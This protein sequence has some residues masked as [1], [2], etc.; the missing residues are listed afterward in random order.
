MRLRGFSLILLCW[1][2]DKL[3]TCNW[4]DI[5]SS[6]ESFM[7]MCL[8]EDNLNEGSRSLPLPL[9]IKNRRERPLLSF[10]S[11]RRYD[12][13]D[14]IMRGIDSYHVVERHLH[15]SF[16]SLNRLNCYRE[17]YLAL[18]QQH[19]QMKILVWSLFSRRKTLEVSVTLPWK[20]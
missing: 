15:Q 14:Y 2:G 10:D 19:F 20:W 11:D 9:S 1:K 13:R 16:H 4:I 17:K 18:F 7:L 8:L 5:T 6:R 3:L 12:S